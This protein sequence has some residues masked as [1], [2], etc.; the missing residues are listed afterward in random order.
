M[1]DTLRFTWSS[2]IRNLD[3]GAVIDWFSIRFFSVGITSILAS[4]FAAGL[5]TGEFGIA[6]RV[7]GLGLIFAG[8]SAVGG[9]IFGLLFG[10]PKSVPQAIP[11]TGSGGGSRPMGKVNTNLEEISDWLTKTIVGVTLTGLTTLPSYVWQSAG[12]LNTFGFG[13]PMGGQLLAA[14]IFVYFTAGGFWIGYVGTRTLLS[15]LFTKFDRSMTQGQSE[16]ILS[17]GLDV[18]PSTDSEH[19]FVVAPA[20]NA[21]VAEA[22]KALL[23]VPLEKLS[24]PQQIAAWGVAHARAN[25][26]NEAVVA[27]ESALRSEPENKEYSQALAAV[28][29]A[30]GRI[31][32]ANKI[33]SKVS[34]PGNQLLDMFYALYEPPPDGFAK[35]IQLG[36]QLNDTIEEERRGIFHVWFACAYGQQYS[37]LM[38]R[39]GGVYDEVV[40]SA[41]SNAISQVEAA[42]KADPGTRPLLLD[43]WKPKPGARDRDLADFDPKDVDLSKL[44]EPLTLKTE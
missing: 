8:A 16:T 40:A 35:A 18:K 26:L 38:V 6:L 2:V 32:D 9:W 17:K 33:R 44:L 30:L 14:A 19:G 39:E 31:E 43:L 29:I 13:W 21:E 7:L 36:K 42:L 37:H 11:E 23:S 34:L 25:M 5:N 15:Q 27:L 24:T 10:I 3:S 20:P 41:R 28:Y 1:P 4:S 12:K 22:D